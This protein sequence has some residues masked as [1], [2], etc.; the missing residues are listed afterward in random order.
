MQFYD[1]HAAD[2]E[3][4]EIVALC[5]DHDGDL[6][7]IEQLDRHLESV[8]RHVWKGRRLPFPVL[9]DSTFRTCESYG[10]RGV[11]QLMLIDPQGKLVQ[12]DTATLARVLAADPG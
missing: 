9:L 11:G 7:S 2:R 12:G 3:R 8:V 1:E 10:V 6:K 4:F 5:V